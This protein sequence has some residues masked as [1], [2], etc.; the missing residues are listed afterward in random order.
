MCAHIFFF[1]MQFFH[2]R[3]ESLCCM[4][5]GEIDAPYNVLMADE[6]EKVSTMRGCMLLL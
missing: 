3:I 1:S 4:D 5:V 6:V 2:L